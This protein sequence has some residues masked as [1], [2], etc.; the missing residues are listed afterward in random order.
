MISTSRLSL[1]AL[2]LAVLFLGASAAPA[3]DSSRFGRRTRSSARSQSRAD[4]TTSEDGT[5]SNGRPGTDGRDSDQSAAEADLYPTA[6]NDPFAGAQ[7]D[8]FTGETLSEATDLPGAR[9]E[10]DAYRGAPRV[11]PAQPGPLGATTRD[12]A[13]RGN[14]PQYVTHFDFQRRTT[15]AESQAVQRRLQELLANA[16]GIRA[17]V[18]LDGDTAILTGHAA[19]DYDR[20]LAERL[21]LLEPGIRTIDNRL[22]VRASDVPQ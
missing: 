21:L 7:V 16:E 22:R 5:F 4:A 1:F 17:E 6:N 18:Q 2:T 15:K 14:L 10:D 3:Q 9:R 11:P 19:T 20:R 13:R 12:R 8:W